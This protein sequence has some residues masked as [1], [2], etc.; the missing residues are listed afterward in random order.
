[1]TALEQTGKGGQKQLFLQKLQL[2]MSKRAEDLLAL[3]GLRKTAVRLK[4]L[5]IFMN[6]RAALS[7]SDVEESFG[8]V[9]RITLY[10]TLK[11]FEDKG[12]IHRA[13]DGSEKSKYA[14]CQSGCDEHEHYDHHAHFHCNACGKTYCL[15]NVETPAVLVPGG[16]KVT[17]MHLI[18]TG[19][20]EV[21]LG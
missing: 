18:V 17:T 6:A 16:F 21:C 14:L 4:V 10:R 19:R 9:D 5:D 12:V 8:P 11:T 15:E 20:C 13:I 3:H 1:M 7:H 2:K